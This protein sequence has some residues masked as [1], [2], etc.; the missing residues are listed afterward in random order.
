MQPPH[1]HPR[2]NLDELKAQIMKKLGPE[3][4]KQY[5]YYLHGFLNLKLN[6]VEFNKLCLRIL[7]RENIPLHNQFI[8]SILKNA[9]SAKTPPPIAS[10]KDDVL[11]HVTH[12]GSKETSD[13]QNGS[14]MVLPVSPRKARTGS[15][16]RKSGDRLS[17]LAPYTKIGTQ[18]SGSHVV[19]ENGNFQSS[20]QESTV[21]KRLPDGLAPVHSKDQTESVVRND[22]EKTASARSPLVAPLGVP[23]GHISIGGARRGLAPA[24]S[25]KFVRE[26]ALLDSGTLREQIEQIAVKQGLEGVSADCA[27]ILNHGLDSYLKGL[28]RSCIGL[29]GAKNNAHEQN[30]RTKLINGVKPGHHYQIQN[31]EVRE[32][33]V[34]RAIS[35]QDFRVAME[36]NPQQLGEDWP[37]LLEKICT[38][39]FEE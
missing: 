4:S 2:I 31:S 9:C 30:P 13:H 36:M 18:S 16:D 22:V 19:L 26:D 3:G 33:K 28:I 39:A 15:R 29:V 32:Q 5:L 27:N 7:G 24:S 6:K 34:N 10:H 37:L 8:R 12:V 17:A 25:G 1:Q 14:H 11:K 23:F 21:V 38:H 20:N 35:L